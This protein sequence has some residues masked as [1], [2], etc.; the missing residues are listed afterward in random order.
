MELFAQNMGDIPIDSE[1]ESESDD[2]DSFSDE[3]NN[4]VPT[5]PYYGPCSHPEMIIDNMISKSKVVMIK[6]IGKI[7]RYQ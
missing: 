4:H 2:Y 3:D 6:D 1:S 5:K 7:K